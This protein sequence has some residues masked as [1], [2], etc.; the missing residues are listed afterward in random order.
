M[1]IDGVPFGEVA[2]ENARTRATSAFID[3]L[4]GKLGITILYDR[5]RVP[6]GRADLLQQTSL[7]QIFIEKGIIEWFGPQLGSP[8]EP[9]IR[10]WSCRVMDEGRRNSAGA[11]SDSDRTALSAAL[12]EA[13]ERYIWW[14]QTDYF[15]RPLRGTSKEIGARVA[16]LRPER[17]A[18][19]TKEQR[20]K[21]GNLQLD[22]NASYLWIEGTSVVSGKKIHV[23]AQQVSAVHRPWNAIPREPL[24]RTQITNGLATWPTKAGARLRGALECL[25]RDAYMVAWFNQLTLPRA[26]L[27][28]LRERSASLDSLVAR[29]EAYA[30]R[31]HV[32]SMLTDAPTYAVC[33][34]VEDTSDVGP[35]FAFGLKANRDLSSAAEGAILE[36]LRARRFTRYD[37]PEEH[38]DPS[39]PVEEV[40][41]RG[42]TYFWWM[43]EHASHLEFFIAGEE[44]DFPEA[45]WEHDSEDMH[46]DRIVNWCRGKG[47]ECVSVPLT[48]SKAN[49]TSW[50]IEMVIMPELQWTHLEEKLKHLAG[51]RLKEVPRQFGYKARE[52]PF[53]AMPHPYS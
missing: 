18:A 5:R 21:S 16:I 45:P 38:F 46:L 37:K 28:T 9:P 2:E 22:P 36:A 20:S 6:H 40:G 41:H 39:K 25:E 1:L 51:E 11:S 43:P 19:F 8:D 48:A 52:T 31:V 50:H 4:E 17:F 53:V 24:I 35:R 29:C 3:F 34:V 42:R 49:P 13:L 32:V 26:K 12:A 10:V 23:P 15:K 14:T 47:Y 7:A 33:A 27:S 30:L 44:K